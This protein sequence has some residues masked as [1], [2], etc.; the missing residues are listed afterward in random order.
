MKMIK[1][2]LFS[3]VAIF[4]FASAQTLFAE[5]PNTEW[6]VTGPDSS[7][8]T[9][10]EVVDEGVKPWVFTLA[11]ANGELK[12]SSAGSSSK[13]NFRT[14]DLSD[15]KYSGY[16]IKFH[17]GSTLRN[18]TT[19]KE[20]YWPNTITYISANTF[21]NCSNLAICD[22]PQDTKMTS[23]G[24]TAFSGCK[25]LIHFSMCD[26]ISS[27]GEDA[28]SGCTK[29]VF[30][31]PMLPN[32][33]TT[34]YARR[35]NSIKG[36]PLKDG[37][38]VVGG[39]GKPVTWVP[40]N[41]NNNNNQYFKGLNITNLIFGAGV[42]NAGTNYYANY[43]KYNPYE[44]CPITNIVVK[45][46]GV[47]AF[48]EALSYSTSTIKRPTTI[49]NY[50]VAGYITGEIVPNATV[51]ATRINAAKNKY[52][53]ELLLKLTPENY[54]LW[55]DVSAE[56]KANYWN[57]FNGG[58]VGTGDEVPHGIALYRTSYTITV[59]G[60]SIGPLT[61]W[62]GIWLV[63]NNGGEWPAVL[64]SVNVPVANEGLAYTGSEQTGVSEGE[65]Y[66]LEGHKATEAG[67]YTATATLKDG[68]KWLDGSLEPKEIIWSI[69]VVQVPVAI[70]GLRYTGSEQTGI[71]ENEAYVLTGHKATE[72]GT[73]TATATLNNGFVWPDGTKEQK[74]VQWSIGEAPIQIPVAIT[75][76]KYTGS[77]LTGVVEASDYTLQGHKATNVGTYTATATLVDTEHY[78]WAD[79]TKDPKTITWTIEG[80]KIPVAITGLQYNG[81]TQT[82]VKAGT[83]YTL[84]GNTGK[85]V[86]TY[87]ATATLLAG[88]MWEDGTLDPKTITWLI[89]E[90]V[91]DPEPEPLPDPEPDTEDTP[92]SI[93]YVNP[94]ATGAN[95]GTSWTDA[96]T[97]FFAA[98]KKITAEKNVIWFAG[99]FTCSADC[100]VTI[101][102]G[103]KAKI[104]G[105]FKGGEVTAAEREE[106]VKSVVSGKVR[107]YKTLEISSDSALR[108]ERIRFI[109]SKDR[110]IYKKGA[111]DLTLVDCDMIACG[112]ALGKSNGNPTH[113]RGFVMVGTPGKT[114]LFATRCTF[115]GNRVG[116]YNNYDAGNGQGAAFMNLARATLDDCLFATNGLPV[117]N[118]PSTYGFRYFKGSAL[119]ATNAP[120][121][122]RGTKFLFNRA[123]CAQEYDQT[124]D[125]N[126]MGATVRLEAGTGRSVFTN[127][128]WMANQNAR[129]INNSTHISRGGGGEIFFN[130]GKT[131]AECEVVNCT[132]AANLNHI[133]KNGG[134]GVNVR[135]G[136]MKILNSIFSDNISIA[137]GTTIGKDI[138]V[139]DGAEVNVSYSMLS[140]D[141]SGD[142]LIYAAGPG[143]LNIGEGVVFDRA[144][145]VSRVEEAR[146]MQSVNAGT[147]FYLPVALDYLI[148]LNVHLR[149]K[150]GYYDFGQNKRIRSYSENSP[151]LDAGD[152]KSDYSKEPYTSWGYHGR[153]VN[154]GFYGNTP[155]A[156]ATRYKGFFVKVVGGESAPKEEVEVIGKPDN[157]VP[158]EDI[159]VCDGADQA[160]KIYRGS[161][162]VWKWKAS[163]DSALAGNTHNDLRGRFNGLTEV[164]VCDYN[165][166]K[167]VAI[168]SSNCAWA[169]VD[170]ATTN[171]IAFGYSRTAGQA[172]RNTIMPH[173]IDLLPN[174]IVAVA[175]T[176]TV[177]QNEPETKYG[178]YFYHIAG[179]KAKSY[180][181]PAKQGATFFSIENPHGFYW[182]NDNKKLYVSSSEGLTRLNVTFN[183]EANKFDIEEEAVFGIAQ[184]GAKWGHDL[185][186]VP[187]TRILAMTAYEMTLFFDMDKEQWLLDE[188]VW[189]MDQK[190]FD[191]HE[192]KIHF[193]STVPRT[194]Y[195]TDT[196]EVWTKEN[197]F[198]E[199]LKVPG[200]KFYKARWAGGVLDSIAK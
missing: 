88:Y 123:V 60:E 71:V 27:I 93:I 181:D 30:N 160:V 152:P 148:N 29:L 80:T 61:I 44:G 81:K 113:G 186:L 10:T 39:A 95:N 1:N 121:T 108:I 162:V 131:Y 155:E 75:G 117:L 102:N 135:S 25:N 110:G 140:P 67:F 38:L 82:G 42:A 158:V 105:G 70:D 120:V 5:P 133:S 24:N 164:R 127:C 34:I 116:A 126:L 161:E 65:G 119:Y 49:R 177:D 90:E 72:V 28:F 136:K 6:K 154:M 52:W 197:G 101:P 97:D 77:E 87:T 21:L 26:T 66:T 130:P 18:N 151:A 48:G 16:V 8:L 149:S 31:G 92:A 115:A 86:G 198:K 170:M 55:K 147:Y 194:D 17:N 98:L 196:L 7:M 134:C 94:A 192:D 163:T 129:G 15:S 106:G 76:L 179:D 4:S 20:L 165:G 182:D 109:E 50:D 107:A 200:A 51:Q 156:A 54:K 11:K 167:V 180:Q 53:Q 58:V 63:F 14:I 103:V 40:Y 187:G 45:N 3:F 173:S 178:C 184:L 104:R 189:R 183:S 199:Y 114:R 22:Y 19:I 137:T 125:A 153:R 9:I 89:D 171:A 157:T 79:G 83:G 12:V 195:V 78:E 43:T 190:G 139:A 185:A 145:F 59:D 84:S 69:G 188:I 122:I 144:N 111:G 33:Y 175:S 176:Y 124:D 13:L 166:K 35:F 47:F 62:G 118:V 159:I 132:F 146:Y 23:I 96:Y 100:V 2:I 112:Y 138:Y 36:K 56:A 172:V 99:T 37:L 73:H 128:L 57:N 193:L 85:A 169:I 191:P 142:R 64:V 143:T 174:D 74:T 41:N 141:K 168:S 91:R 68:Y 32:S 46:P 150:A